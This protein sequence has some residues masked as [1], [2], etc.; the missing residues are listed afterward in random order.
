MALFHQFTGKTKKTPIQ[1]LTLKI[2]NICFYSFDTRNYKIGDASHWS[3]QTVLNG[4]GFFEVKAKP[5]ILALEAVKSSD[6]GIYRCR[7]D[8][9]K[10]PTKNSKINLTVISK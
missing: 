8:F 6:S 1:I 3:D 2:S 5:A 4:R 7:A 10:T 9:Q